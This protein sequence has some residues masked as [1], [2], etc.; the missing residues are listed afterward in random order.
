MRLRIIVLTLALLFVPVGSASASPAP[1][2]FRCGN[3]YTLAKS[4]GWRDKDWARLDYLIWRESRCQP[5]ARS[6]T[7]DTGLMQIN[8]VHLGWLAEYGITQSSLYD[9]KT[10]LRAGRLL[11]KKAKSWYGCGWQ[12]WRLC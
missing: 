2:Y 11:F 8:D 12:P 5:N 1:H 6:V 9:P 4:V 7:R 3:W 10:N